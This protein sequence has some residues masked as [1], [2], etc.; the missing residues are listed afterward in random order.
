MSKT[1]KLTIFPIFF[2]FVRFPSIIFKKS[3]EKIEN[4]SNKVRT[5]YNLLRESTSSIDHLITYSTQ[6]SL[7]IKFIKSIH[8]SL[9]SEFNVIFKFYFFPD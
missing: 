4:L 9:H 7:E 1:K 2:K 5:K 8:Y 6:K 3:T